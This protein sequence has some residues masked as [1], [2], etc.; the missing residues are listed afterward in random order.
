LHSATGHIVTGSAPESPGSRLYDIRLACGDGRR[1]PMPLAKFSVLVKDKTG[2]YY[3]PATLSLLERMKQGWRWEDIDVLA[4]AD[5]QQ[6]GRVW[7]SA[8]EARD[9]A[10]EAPLPWIQ[11]RDSGKNGELTVDDL[12][13]ATGFLAISPEDQADLE[14]HEAARRARRRPPVA[15]APAGRTPGAGSQSPV[16]RG[17]RGPKGKGP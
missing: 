13:V 16:R 14:A 6:R 1:D 15:P 7:L 2:V 12:P 8:F 10:P 9:L 11:Q 5:P 4:R 3:D 17:S